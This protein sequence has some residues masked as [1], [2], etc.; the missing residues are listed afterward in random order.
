MDLFWIL[1]AAVVV[2][3]SAFVVWWFV[4]RK[5][6]EAPILDILDK[7]ER[8]AMAKIEFKWKAKEKYLA[9]K[10]KVMVDDIDDLSSASETD[11]KKMK[12]ALWAR[13]MEAV[14]KIWMVQKEG[15]H[16]ESAKQAG[17]LG[18]GEWEQ[19]QQAVQDLNFE[20]EEIK[21]EVELVHPEE[22]SELYVR[23]CSESLAKIIQTKNQAVQRQME[24]AKKQQ[25]L[26]AQEAEAKRLAKENQLK[27][28]AALD[29]EAKRA[30]IAEATYQ[31][32]MREGGSQSKKVSS[33]GSQL[34]R[35]K[36]SKKKR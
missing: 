18:A 3:I 8:A 14:Q 16:F 13:T 24:E 35:K 28:Q 20:M 25:H 30:K 33:S 15:K 5:E 17:V 12:A 22:Q 27:K 10:E 1:M 11:V 36:S 34:L 32:L 9:L 19:Y 2:G 21:I 23:K 6:E 26:R 4:F 29:A 31:E 7:S